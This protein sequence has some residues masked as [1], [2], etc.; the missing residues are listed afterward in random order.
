[1]KKLFVFVLACVLLLSTAAFA[2]AAPAAVAES[3]CNHYFEV[4]VDKAATCEEKGLT[5]YT[6]TECGYSFSV[7]TLPL[8]HSY[9]TTV[10]PATCDQA[11]YTEH[12]CANCGDS[13]VDDY[14]PALGHQ[15]TEEVIPAT[16]AAEGKIVRTCSVCGAVEEEAIPALD[17]TYVYQND[18]VLAESGAVVSYG[19]KVCSVCG[20]TAPATADDYASAEPVAT[21]SGEASAEP[22]GD[23]SGE[24]AAEEEAV[25]EIQNPNY[26]PASYNWATIEIVLVVVIAVVFVVL[27]L[28][29][30]KKKEEKAQDPLE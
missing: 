15:F 7:E 24:P 8:G 21:A 20:A 5:T 3:E 30:G 27:M 2:A 6:C 14:T 4:T 25:A 26:D 10:V 23:A 19:T 22:A 1:M 16:C 13:Y 12:V 11:G 29:F 18:A 28:S 9:V 17:H